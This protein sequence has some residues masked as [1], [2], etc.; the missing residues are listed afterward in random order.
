MSFDQL[1]AFLAIGTAQIEIHREIQT[2]Y[3]SNLITVNHVRKWCRK[4][5]GCR[6]IVTDE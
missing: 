6:V 1:L 3:G 4:F 2:V 5:S